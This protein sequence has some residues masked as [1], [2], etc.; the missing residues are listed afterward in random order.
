M[1]EDFEVKGPHDELLEGGGK[2]TVLTLL[3][4][5]AA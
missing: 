4:M 1:N 3:N 5:A 2:R